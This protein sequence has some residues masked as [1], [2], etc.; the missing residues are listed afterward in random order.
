MRLFR[1]LH[2]LPE[3]A[4]ST[5]IRSQALNLDALAKRVPLIGRP[6]LCASAR[7]PAHLETD[8]GAA[9]H[10]V[11]SIAEGRSIFVI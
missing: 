5:L 9:R 3:A 7:G 4:P 1:Q 10:S 2:L 8:L 6:V 11:N